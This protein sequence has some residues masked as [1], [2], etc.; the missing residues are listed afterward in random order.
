LEGELAEADT[1]N[2]RSFGSGL[3]RWRKRA[4]TLLRS[5]R[6]AFDLEILSGKS[7]R[8]F[9]NAGSKNNPGRGRQNPHVTAGLLAGVR[10]LVPIMALI[11]DGDPLLWA[12]S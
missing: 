1:Q 11:V 3:P 9:R 7:V 2:T 5:G 4:G 6:K 12:M 10:T 8:L